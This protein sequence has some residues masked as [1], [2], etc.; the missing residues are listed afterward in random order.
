MKK[1]WVSATALSCFLTVALAVGCTSNS[2]APLEDSSS[3]KPVQLG[4]LLVPFDPPPLTEL[5]QTAAWVDRPVVNF[6]EYLREHLDKQGL[7]PVSAEQAIAM[8]NNS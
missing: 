3:S 8:R 4:D 2:E 7:P 6:V 5:E 1:R